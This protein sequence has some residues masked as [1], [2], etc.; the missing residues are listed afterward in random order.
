MKVWFKIY[1]GDD[2]FYLFN[3]YIVKFIAIVEILE[4]L[5][6]QNRP[7]SV[8]DIAT[9]L[10]TISKTVCANEIRFT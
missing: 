5:Q 6:R 10:N 4:Y 1:I 7:Y 2:L 8:N 9:V 3:N